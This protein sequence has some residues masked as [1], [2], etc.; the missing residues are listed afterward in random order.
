MSPSSFSPPWCL[1]E[2]SNCLDLHPLGSRGRDT[3]THIVMHP[4]VFACVCVCF[5]TCMF[6]CASVL[7]C[8]FVCMC[9]CARARVCV[10]VCIL[11]HVFFARMPFTQ[12]CQQI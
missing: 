10:F 7:V 3:P 4:G 11:V 6:L 9:F 1:K 12:G 5:C 2:G 8:V